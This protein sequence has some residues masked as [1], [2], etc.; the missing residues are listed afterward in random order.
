MGAGPRR[1]HGGSVK[2]GHSAP[3][4]DL[5]PLDGDLLRAEGARAS[6]ADDFGHLVSRRPLA[7][8][9]TGSVADVSATIRWAAAHRR[10]VAARGQGHSV[11]GRAQ[12]ED[13]IVVDLSPFADVRRP[14][15]GRVE[16]GAGA[17]WRSVIAAT[18]PAGLVPPVLPTYLDLSVGGTISVGG[19]G[20]ATHRHGLVTDTVV[21]LQV[22]TGE[23]KVL[24]CSRD[25]NAD[26]FD[27][28]R[29]G[30]GQVGIITRAVVSLVPAP[31][32]A[33]RYTLR[34]ADLAALAAGQELLLRTGRADHL[35]GTVMPAGPGW[36]YQLDLAV[37]HSPG[38]EPDDA[39][40]LRDLADDRSEA[41]ID[42]VPHGAHLESFDR[43]TALLRSTGEWSRPHPWMLT[44]LP[45]PV[46]VPTAQAVLEDLTPD[47]LG[48]HGAVLFHPVATTAFSTPLA[49]LPDEAVVYPFNL[50]RFVSRPDDG[51]RAAAMVRQNQQ[52]HRRV[53]AAGG[54]L[55]P[56]SALPFS[57]A[58][59][60]DHFGPAWRS[61]Q[62]ARER[63]DPHGIL[64]PGYRPAVGAGR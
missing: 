37:L 40:V 59:W 35:Q 50:V 8:L 44:F 20:A 63:F 42:D 4:A 34:F 31:A 28:V 13:G 3:W 5:P 58:D 6:A 62:E 30:L 16:V 9:R 11:Y 36:R 41:Q 60:R 19:V 24:T 53:R 64:A 27:H 61:F 38:Q 47:D 26:L 48:D 29:A 51:S 17:T 55:Y 2:D 25:E 14:A 32:R 33:R 54:T 7:V 12:A 1:R 49:Q 21:E 43:V 23:G 56:V 22:V 39:A 15:A 18:L 10:D 46:A 45:G 57:E 52:I